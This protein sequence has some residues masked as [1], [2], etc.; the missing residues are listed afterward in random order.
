MPKVTVAIP[1]YNRERY[2]GQAI[3]SVLDQTYT[4][5]ELLI[6]DNASSDNTEKL[7]KSLS[8][9]R[10]RYVRNDFNMGIIA[11]WN[12]AVELS[13]GEYLL[14]L[15]DDDKLLPRFLA[16]SVEILDEYPTVAFTFSHCNKVDE[17]GRVLC[18]WGYDYPPAGL[19]HG[20]DY[21]LLTVKY[22]C[23]LTNSSTVLIRRRVVETAGPFREIYGHNTFDFNMWLRVANL[24]D[25]YFIDETLV[26]YRLHPHQMSERHWRTPGSPTGP[27]GSMFEIIGAIA[28]ILRK[29]NMQN[30]ENL[31]LVT[32]SLLHAN[33]RCAELVKGL[34]S[35]L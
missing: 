30:E 9:T 17:L 35:D 23:C 29:R 7:V 28:L 13:Q 31:K 18:R 4:D 22:C 12:R 14:I 25:L 33:A 27:I 6:V 5:L 20:E 11:N 15:G 16:T 26:D 2:L 21:L 3:Q 24:F 1:T 10:L 34:V 19:L 8:D 32:E